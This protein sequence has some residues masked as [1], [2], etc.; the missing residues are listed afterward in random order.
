MESSRKGGPR[1]PF[2]NRAKVPGDHSGGATPVP[3]PNTEVKTASADGTW[4]AAPWESRTSPGYSLQRARAVVGGTGPLRVRNS[5]GGLGD[6]LD[7]M[8]SGSGRAAGPRGAKA[9]APK[10]RVAGSATSKARTGTGSRSATGSRSVASSRSTTGSR[11]AAS[12]R[13]ASGSRSGTGSRSAGSS[14]QARSSSARTDHVGRPSSAR[15]GSSTSRG[16]SGATRA[17][18]RVDASAGEGRP[19]RSS[20]TGTGAG[21]GARARTSARDG[22]GAGAWARPA[23]PGA[24]RSGGRGF[25]AAARTSGRSERFGSDRPRSLSSFRGDA[26][27]T[28]RGPARDSAGRW[29]RSEDRPPSRQGTGV[30]PSR[31]RSAS[32]APRP[33]ART[34]GE[35]IDRPS[36]GAGSGGV[37]SGEGRGAREQG[38]G[39]RSDRANF[40][41]RSAGDGPRWGRPVAPAGRAGA[42]AAGRAA[43]RSDGPRSA[44]P[45]SSDAQPRSFGAPP[46]SFDRASR[47]SD[48][49]A[50]G[51]PA[52]ARPE[53]CKPAGAGPPRCRSGS[54]AVEPQPAGRRLGTGKH[55]A[56]SVPAVMRVVPA[57]SRAGWPRRERPPQRDGWI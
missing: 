40:S 19:R 28:A 20:A 39:L 13:S 10:K 3:I 11:S 45:R 14:A 21:G 18:S 16:V 26:G 47:P 53:D 17:S 5:R 35:R 23:A 27:G 12:S 31:S 32:G 24:S 7:D 42:G 38:A 57:A 52:G 30:P 4:G 1:G 56:P 15:T 43:G 25:G 36:R 55:L 2:E 54:M 37:F 50:G 8:A 51:G 44:P 48:E 46:R 22:A 33:P 6:M 29:A 34:Y 41:D 9:G 49:R